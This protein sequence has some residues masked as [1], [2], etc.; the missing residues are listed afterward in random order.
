[1]P[2]GGTTRGKRIQGLRPHHRRSLKCISGGPHG[3]SGCNE[4]RLGMQ[5]VRSGASPPGPGERSPNLRLAR[6]YTSKPFEAKEPAERDARVP[7]SLWELPRRVERANAVGPRYNQTELAENSQLS[8]S[9]ISKLASW[10]NL[11]GLRLDTL[12][13]LAA[14]LNVSV[15]WLLGDTKSPRRAPRPVP[16]KPA[17]QRRNKPTKKGKKT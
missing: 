5:S 17:S 3:Y 15:S 6:R 16:I 9:V 14:A 4:I 13:K 7:E 10:S 12:F 1:M 8:Q 11:Y 2:A